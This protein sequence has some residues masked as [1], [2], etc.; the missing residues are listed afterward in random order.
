MVHPRTRLASAPLIVALLLAATGAAAQPQADIIGVYFD[1]EGLHN[2][3]DCI[4]IVMLFP[5]YVIVRDLTEPAIAVEFNASVDPSATVIQLAILLPPGLVYIVPPGEN[6]DFMI[7][8][9]EPS[10]TDLAVVVTI[11]YIFIA[12]GWAEWTI[13]PVANPAL[14]G[15]PAYF[16][17]GNPEVAL[18]LIPS[19][20]SV[21]ES[22]ALA[23]TYCDYCYGLPIE[24]TP[25]STV[26]GLY[27]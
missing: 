7:G 6:G 17:A 19:S 2:C 22:V 15:L 21:D 23:T 18:P 1:P 3:R 16:P 13:G 24:E 20:E 5:V 25:W 14:P 11:Q 9:A 27:R 12:D 8:F 10:P 4:Q 26:K